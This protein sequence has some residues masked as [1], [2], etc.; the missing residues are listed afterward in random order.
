MKSEM[1]SLAYVLRGDV[2]PPG[3]CTPRQLCVVKEVLCMYLRVFYKH[4][5]D[6]NKIS[7]LSDVKVVHNN[8]KASLPLECALYAMNL[9]NVRE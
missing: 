6:S 1:R 4:P 5:T 2:L 3:S 7:V 8:F 9:V